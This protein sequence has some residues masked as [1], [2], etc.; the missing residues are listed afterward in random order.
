[1]TARVY[2]LGGDCHYPYSCAP[3]REFELAKLRVKQ[4]ERDIGKAKDDLADLER[5][6]SFAEVPREWRQ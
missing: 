2:G 4:L 6:A 1:M 3:A 5:R